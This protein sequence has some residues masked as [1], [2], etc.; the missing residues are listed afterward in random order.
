MKLPVSTEWV[1]HCATS[2]A[3]LDPGASASTT[4]LAQYYDLPAPSL[5]KQLKALVKAGVLS[6]TTGPRGG[7][8][9]ARPAAQITLLEIVEAVDG[10]SSPFECREIRRQGRGGLPPEECGHACLLAARMADAH[11]AWRSSLADVTLADVLADL[12]P[13]APARTRALLTG[14]DAP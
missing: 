13:A 10:A 5:A 1:L 8:R 9:L 3:Q 6:A 4:Q 12:P 11:R 14:P 7:F 2:L